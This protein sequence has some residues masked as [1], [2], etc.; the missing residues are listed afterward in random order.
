MRGHRWRT[1]TFA[2]VVATGQVRDASFARIVRLRLG[3]LAGDEGVGPSA[4]RGFKIA[5]RAT[6]AP[7]YV[8]DSS[9]RTTDKD[10]GPI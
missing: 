1:K 5:L 8:F 3:D 4:N 6:A 10:Y 9:W 2:G 7:C